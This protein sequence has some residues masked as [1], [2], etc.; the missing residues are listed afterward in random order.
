RTI[1]KGYQEIQKRTLTKWINVQLGTVGDSITNIET[2]LRDGRKLLSLLSVVA[3]E[4][5]PK[6][7][8]G[9]M[10]IHHLSNVA[11]V[12]SFLEKQTGPGALP[13]I[14]TEAI[15]NGD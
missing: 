5:V 4:P 15:V 3:K 7:E 8:K 11:Q 10:R 13:D 12:F 14:G 2:D 6:P 9:K 1:G